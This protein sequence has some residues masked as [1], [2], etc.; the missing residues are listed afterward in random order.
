MTQVSE[1]TSVL[2]V[3]KVKNWLSVLEICVSGHIFR[4]LGG[5]KRE[6]INISNRTHKF[7]TGLGHKEDFPLLPDCY[8]LGWMD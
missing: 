7:A 5:S 2:A 1:K 8:W 4:V 6:K 3:T